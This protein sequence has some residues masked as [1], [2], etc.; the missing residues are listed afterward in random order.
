MRSYPRSRKVN[1]LVREAVA[2]TLLEEVKDPRVDMVTVTSVDVSRDT[3]YATIYVTA[4]ADS[5]DE[6]LAGLES[7][8]GRIKT[9]LARRV[10]LRFTPELHFEIDSSVDH[11]MRISEILHGGREDDD[12]AAE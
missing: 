3:R 7:A 2:L 11:G 10:K 5:Y 9:G 4:P 1:E 8:C 6:A 12:W